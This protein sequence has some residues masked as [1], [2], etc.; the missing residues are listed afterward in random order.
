M[1]AENLAKIRGHIAQICSRCGRDPEEVTL[2][3]ISKYADARQI[4]EAITAGLTH[5]GE[6][7]VQDAGLKFKQISS[8]SSVS[9]HLVGHLQT[10]KARSALELFTLIESVD[11][12]RLADALQKHAGELGRGVDIL[13]QV[14]IAGEEQKY[15]LAPEAVRSFVEHVLKECPQLRL[16]GLMTIAPLTEDAETVRSCFRGLREAAQRLAREFGGERQAQF[17]ELSMGMSAD[18]EIAIEEGATMVRIGR[19]IFYDH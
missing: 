5:V 7:R 3:G 9:R 10:N 1:I 13:A 14:N 19:A 15:G 16:R 18:Y 2:V 8:I 6:N 12:I 17:S 11:S 4:E